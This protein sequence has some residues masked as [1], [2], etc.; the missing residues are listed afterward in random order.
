[1]SLYTSTPPSAQPLRQEPFDEYGLDEPLDFWQGDY[2]GIEHLR[3]DY[4]DPGTEAGRFP[5][6]VVRKGRV[7][8]IFNSW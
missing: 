2:S 7:N 5:Y 8:G 1:M 4:I 6:Y 3:P